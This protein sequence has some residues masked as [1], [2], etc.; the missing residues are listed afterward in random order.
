MKAVA[1]SD[2]RPNEIDA[3]LKQACQTET[4]GAPTAT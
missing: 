2:T 4:W 1:A 3:G